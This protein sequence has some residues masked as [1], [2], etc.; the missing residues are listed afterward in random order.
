MNRDLISM[1]NNKINKKQLLKVL[2]CIAFI[3]EEIM[4]E[5]NFYDDYDDIKE[6]IKSNLREQIKLLEDSVKDNDGDIN[7]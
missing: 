2:N 6:D 7:E 5:I 1:D 4:D 3:L